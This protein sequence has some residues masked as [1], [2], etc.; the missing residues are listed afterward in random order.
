ML[1]AISGRKSDAKIWGGGVVM[2]TYS[3]QRGILLSALIQ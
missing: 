3:A 2:Y 1:V